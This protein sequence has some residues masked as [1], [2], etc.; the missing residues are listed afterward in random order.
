MSAKNGMQRSKDEAE[1][2]IH[3]VDKIYI[4]FGLELSFKAAVES[5]SN[6]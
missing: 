3:T 5:G 2:F 1:A 4:Y 6:P